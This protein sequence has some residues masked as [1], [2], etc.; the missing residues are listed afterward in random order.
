MN[1]GFS[2]SIFNNTVTTTQRTVLDPIGTSGTE[3]SNPYYY[4]S[5]ALT[6]D[7]LEILDIIETDYT[8]NLADQTYTNIP[9]S[10]ESYLELY[11]YIENVRKNLKNSDLQL[12]LKIARDGL[13][14]SVNAYGLYNANLSLTSTIDTLETEIEDLLSSKNSSR[15]LNKTSGKLSVNKYFSLAPVYAFYIARFGIPDSGIG[16]DPILLEKLAAQLKRAG[17]EPYG[18]S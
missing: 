2:K 5:F 12:L 10:T 14:G 9:Y 16:F 18:S 6:P 8:N 3:G 13:Q 1:S 15:A 17:I 7:T 4:S 11:S